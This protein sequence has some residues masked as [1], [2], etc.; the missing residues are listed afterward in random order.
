ME[1][2]NAEGKGHMAKTYQHQL[3]ADK[4]A[5]CAYKRAIVHSTAMS[6]SP[7]CLKAGKAAKHMLCSRES[8]DDHAKL[9]IDNVG[10]QISPRLE[11]GPGRW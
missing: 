11:Q 5:G 6:T 1:V 2:S 4:G 7:M 10:D 9:A 3:I 8:V